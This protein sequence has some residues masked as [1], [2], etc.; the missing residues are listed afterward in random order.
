MRLREDAENIAD[1]IRNNFA[2]S[3][4]NGVRSTVDGRREIVS[5]LK[6]APWIPYIVKALT[7]QQVTTL[8]AILQTNEE[9][10]GLTE[11]LDH[12][13]LSEH[14][15]P[16]TSNIFELDESQICAFFESFSRAVHQ[17]TD[18]AQASSVLR[19]GNRDL[20]SLR[21]PSTQL[22]PRGVA[23]LVGLGVS[24]PV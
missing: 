23:G 20:L 24:M 7:R 6:F 8:L 3:L 12:L 1:W 9:T 17:A 10:F 22:T 15:Y 13:T 18:P 19:L 14:G 11:F 16:I 5:K 4:G 21:S 2:Q